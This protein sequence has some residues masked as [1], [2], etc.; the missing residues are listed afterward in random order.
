MAD[1]APSRKRICNP[2]RMCSGL[3]ADL[4]LIAQRGAATAGVR[5]TQPAGLEFD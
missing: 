5:R 1:G 4:D 3:V 2:V